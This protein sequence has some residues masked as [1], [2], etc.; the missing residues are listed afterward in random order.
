MWSWFLSPWP[1]PGRSFDAAGVS[2][3]AGGSGGAEAPGLGVGVG[4]G[5]GV[6][7]GVGVGTGAGFGVGF[8]GIGVGRGFGVGFGATGEGWIGRVVTTTVSPV[9][10][11]A[12]GAPGFVTGNLV[13]GRVVTGSLVTG[14]LVTG[15]FVPGSFVLGKVAPGGLVTGLPAAGESTSSA[16]RRGCGSTIVGRVVGTSGSGLAGIKVRSV[17]GETGIR[18]GWTSEGSSS[19]PRQK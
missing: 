12:R 13:T 10:G 5:I 14:S 8:R 7:G 2:V 9:L 11:S 3:T 6:G 1:Q 19:A 16:D 15:G 17:P 4:V 18:S